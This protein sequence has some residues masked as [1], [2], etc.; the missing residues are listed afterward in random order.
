MQ[1]APFSTLK[2]RGKNF[3]IRIYPILHKEN[4]RNIACRGILLPILSLHLRRIG[5]C[6]MEP[7]YFREPHVRWSVNLMPFSSNSHRFGAGTMFR[8]RKS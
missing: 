8:Y 5:A 1:K 2:L 6:P 7:D 4:S 3:Y